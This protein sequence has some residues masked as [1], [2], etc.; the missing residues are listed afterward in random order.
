MFGVDDAALALIAAGLVS[1]AGSLYVNRQNLKNQNMVN[2]VNWQIAAQNNATQIEMANTAHRRE[3]ADLRAAGLN[4]ILSAGGSGSSTPSLTSVRGDA[5][6]IEN[7]VN[8]L[9]SSAKGL[10]R[11]FGDTYRT[12]LDQAKADVSNTW[13]QNDILKNQ[14]E[15]SELEADQARIANNALHEL[16]TEKRQVFDSKTGRYRWD[17]ELDSP[18]SDYYKAVR[19][20]LLQEAKVRSHAMLWQGIQSGSQVINSASSLKNAFSPTT[21]RKK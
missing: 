3:V 12:Q 20:G 6:Q 15:I 11:F 13:L 21:R 4:P 17:L 19:E 5:A 7:P 9:A 1:T 14:H 8:G 16:T 2:D 18:N 10:A